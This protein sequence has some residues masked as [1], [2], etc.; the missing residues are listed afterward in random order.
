MTLDDLAVS[1]LNLLSKGFAALCLLGNHR[2]PRLVRTFVRSRTIY[3]LGHSLDIST[4]NT[5]VDTI[6]VVG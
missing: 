2:V 6:K 3:I 5:I 4:Q 1:L